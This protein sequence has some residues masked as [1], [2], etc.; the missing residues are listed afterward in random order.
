MNLN[1]LIVH[2]LLYGVLLAASL[3]TVIMISLYY[4]P[5][6]W[7]QDAPAEVQAVAPPLSAADK[8]VKMMVSGLFFAILIG[9]VAVSLWRLRAMSGASLST[10]N[11]A[12]S[13]FIIFETFNLVDLLVIDW[14][15]VEWWRPSF[16]TIPGAE[17]MN[18]FGGYAYHFRGFLIGTVYS[19]VAGLIVAAVVAIA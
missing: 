13:V 17:G 8:R 10:F 3:S 5:M 9:V 11:A 19:L 14:L 18:Q 2:S 16:I 4:W 12:V 15:I 1:S 6:I 7:V